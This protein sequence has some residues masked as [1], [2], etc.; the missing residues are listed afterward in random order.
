MLALSPLATEFPISAEKLG[1]IVQVRSP[2]VIE[3][4]LTV[5]TTPVS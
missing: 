1:E 2:T 5:V 4:E 3:F